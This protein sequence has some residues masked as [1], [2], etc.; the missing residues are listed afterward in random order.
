MNPPKPDTTNH[1][2]EQTH[3]I[4]GAAMAVHTELGHGFLEA[5][6]QE[7]L[8]CEFKARGIPYT[9]E[10]ELPIHYRGKP[11]KTAY[12]ADFVCYGDVIVE[13][14]AL[15]QLS[16]TEE[17]QVIN[18]LKVSRLSKALLFNFGTPRLAYKRLVMSRNKPEIFSSA[19]DAD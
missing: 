17:S 3:A 13:L 1:R 4:I 9:R 10:H 5:V 12:R 11:L 14:K 7:A 6:Y 2:D 18:Y 15:Q 19:D 8:K 16:G